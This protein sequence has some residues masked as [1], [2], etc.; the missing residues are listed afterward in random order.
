[1]YILFYTSH[2]LENLPQ[3]KNLLWALCGFGLFYAMWDISSE[4]TGVTETNKK[5]N[6]YWFWS[7]TEY[8]TNPSNNISL[9]GLEKAFGVFETA[10][11]QGDR[12]TR[13]SC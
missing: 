4:I 11:T 8:D 13:Q 6:I 3:S 12:V 1:M 7:K 9:R 10:V 5:K 2:I